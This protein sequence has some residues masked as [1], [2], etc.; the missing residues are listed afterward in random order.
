MK[1][2]EEYSKAYMEG[3]NAGRLNILQRV[4]IHLQQQTLSNIHEIS[5]SSLAIRNYN[6]GLIKIFELILEEYK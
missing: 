3:V 4:I 1:K 2:E 5:D 6:K